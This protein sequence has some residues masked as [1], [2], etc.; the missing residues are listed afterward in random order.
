[1]LTVPQKLWHDGPL[2]NGAGA[3]LA[4]RDDRQHF[5]DGLSIAVKPSIEQR[6]NANLS[7]VRKLIDLYGSQGLGSGRRAVADTDLLRA[8][9][10]LLHATLDDLIRSLTQ[11]KLPDAPPESLEEIP[12]TGFKGPKF[13]L[14]DLARHH[15]GQAID[16]VIEKSVND[17]CEGLTYNHPGQIEAALKRIAL[18]TAVLDR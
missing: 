4:T 11:W 14:V 3:A 13:S 16:D 8:A 12:L 9:V 15:R 1:L 7:R 2:A 18:S 5:R 17:H 6:F 10:V